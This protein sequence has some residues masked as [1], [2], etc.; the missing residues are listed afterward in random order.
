MER[1]QPELA[2]RC[3]SRNIDIPYNREAFENQLMKW[4]SE[5]VL[6]RTINPKTG[7]PWKREVELVKLAKGIN[8]ILQHVR[9]AGP[10]MALGTAN[11]GNNYAVQAEYSWGRLSDGQ[12]WVRSVSFS[13]RDSEERIKKA[14]TAAENEAIR[15]NLPHRPP[16]ASP[17]PDPFPAEDH[18]PTFE[19]DR[20]KGKELVKKHF[21]DPI[22]AV[23]RKAAKMPDQPWKPSIDDAVKPDPKEFGAK[24]S[25]NT[26]HDIFTSH[27]A[28]EVAKIR[29]RL[30]NAFAAGVINGL[31]GQ[32]TGRPSDP[33]L[34][35][36]YELGRSTVRKLTDKEKYQIQL[37][38]MEYARKNAVGTWGFK[39]NAD[40][41]VFPDDYKKSWN[42]AILERSLLTQL[43]KLDSLIR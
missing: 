12:W 16:P 10:R 40:E 1:K 8:E 9:N 26:F 35:Q 11:G 32:S 28:A 34:K 20:E 42:A 24:M 2:G 38:L 36:A 19:E 39:L 29:S 17:L 21:I 13:I 33:A 18:V 41:W 6:S 22:V 27:K 43:G 3:R 14:A 5:C 37:A 31:T 15:R 30:F 23:G 4:I 7:A 25:I